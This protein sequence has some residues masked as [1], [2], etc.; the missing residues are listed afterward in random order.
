[1]LQDITG[2]GESMEDTVDGKYREAGDKFGEA[3]EDS[4]FVRLQTVFSRL[5]L[6]FLSVP[7]FDFLL[8]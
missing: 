5:I 8:N 7:L 6:I 4:L 3:N 1:M 2:D